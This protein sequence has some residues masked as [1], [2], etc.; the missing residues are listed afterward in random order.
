MVSSVEIIRNNMIATDG[1]SSEGAAIEADGR[2][3]FD[4]Q[5]AFVGSVND[6]SSLTGL[7]TLQGDFLKKDDSL[8]GPEEALAEA[9][10]EFAEL[11]IRFDCAE[12]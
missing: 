7:V 10:D 3:V 6:T 11:W 8:G 1:I 9:N 12:Q 5:L 4:C 2:L